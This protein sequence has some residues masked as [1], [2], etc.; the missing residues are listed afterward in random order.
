M[1]SADRTAWQIASASE[2]GR[3]RP[4]NE[5]HCGTFA[6]DAGARLFVVADGMGGHRGGATA[7]Q[8]AVDAMERSF[9]AAEGVAGDWLASTIR[10]ANRACLLYTSPSPRD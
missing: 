10:E 6:N 4:H 3:V 1:A 9:R 2:A 5:D 8:T 7:S